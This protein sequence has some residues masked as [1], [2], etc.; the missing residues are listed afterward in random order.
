MRRGGWGAPA[1]NDGGSLQRHVGGSKKV[2]G[3]CAGGSLIRFYLLS[4]VGW[5]YCE[6]ES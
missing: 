2:R 1:S 5:E 3:R 6:G 4:R